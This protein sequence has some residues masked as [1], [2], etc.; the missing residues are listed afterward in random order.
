M[1]GFDDIK[2][3]K[4]TGSTGQDIPLI[5]GMSCPSGL[6]VRTVRTNVRF[7]RGIRDDL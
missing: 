6:G 5:G 7:V 3:L 4:P 1:S 2:I